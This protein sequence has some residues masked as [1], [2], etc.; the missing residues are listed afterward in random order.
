[1]AR[2]SRLPAAERIR[3]AAEHVGRDATVHIDQRIVK[4]RLHGRVVAVARSYGDVASDV[5][6]VQ[7]SSTGTVYAVSLAMVMR[8]DDD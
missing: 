3:A 5:A 8:I 2:L 7:Q 6:V 4:A 1:M